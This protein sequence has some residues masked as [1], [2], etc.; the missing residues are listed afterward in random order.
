[1]RRTAFILVALVVVVGGA[2]KGLRSANRPASSSALV[3][4]LRRAYSEA[5]TMEERRRVCLRALDENVIRKG[6]SV[7]VVDQIFGLDSKSGSGRRILQDPWRAVVTGYGQKPVHDVRVIDLGSASRG[8]SEGQPW[9]LVVPRDSNGLWWHLCNCEYMEGPNEI[10]RPSV[11]RT[12]AYLSPT[13]HPDDSSDHSSEKLSVEYRTG[14]DRRAVALR[15]I[16]EGVIHEG[17]PVG[18]VDK[19][20]GTR[21]DQDLELRDERYCNVEFGHGPWYLSVSLAL[22]RGVRRVVCYSMSNFEPKGA[23]Q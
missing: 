14:G 8:Q 22:D 23:G 5:R 17:A 7:E 3:E 20:F 2:T 1:M 9:Y 21:C 18:V 6:V 12:E 4:E 11:S 13:P 19:V 16:D 10:W 15:A